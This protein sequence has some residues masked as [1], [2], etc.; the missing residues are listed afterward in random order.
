[1]VDV[2]EVSRLQCEL[3]ALKSKKLEFEKRITTLVEQKRESRE[4]IVSLLSE[5]SK[6]V[7]DCDSLEVSVKNLQNELAEVKKHSELLRGTLWI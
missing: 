7:S 2:D 5:N 3:T 4:K 6:M 1:M